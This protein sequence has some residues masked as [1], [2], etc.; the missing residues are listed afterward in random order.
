MVPT[1]GRPLLERARTAPFVCT[2]KGIREHL[3]EFHQRSLG[4]HVSSEIAN[5]KGFQLTSSEQ[6]CAR[7]PM[8]YFSSLPLPVTELA[9]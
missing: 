7:F 3:L 4:R 5:K 9:W 8:F 6:H 1:E 2:L